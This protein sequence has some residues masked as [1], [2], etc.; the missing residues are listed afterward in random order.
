MAVP[1]GGLGNRRCGPHGRTVQ[2]A[3][4]GRADRYATI[5]G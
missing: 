1:D 5:Q 2:I 4:T 3:G